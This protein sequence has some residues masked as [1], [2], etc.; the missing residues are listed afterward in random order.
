MKKPA[1]KPM[2]GDKLA[3]SP[4]DKKMKQRAADAVAGRVRPSKPVGR[5]SEQA[6]RRK[7]LENTQL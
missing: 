1:P 3:R 4:M 6:A 5:V 2:K 7:R